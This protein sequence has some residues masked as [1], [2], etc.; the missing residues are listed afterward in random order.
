MG[1]C[2]GANINLNKALHSNATTCFMT[3][4][5]ARIVQAAVY[6]PEGW[7]GNFTPDVYHSDTSIAEALKRMAE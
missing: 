3:D 1:V 2:A 7:T 5:S 6:V 4:G